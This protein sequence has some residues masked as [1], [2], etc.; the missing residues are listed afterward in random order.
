MELL[1]VKS[2]NSDF[3]LFTLVNRGMCHIRVVLSYNNIECYDLNEYECLE[4][5]KHYV[6]S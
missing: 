3:P 2:K 6:I 5:L 1:A 4:R